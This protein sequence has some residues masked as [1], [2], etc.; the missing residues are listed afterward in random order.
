MTIILACDPGEKNFGMS[1][2][3]ITAK[4]V[5][6]LETDM[7]AETIVNL[8]SNERKMT[9]RAR[10]Q[11]ADFQTSLRRFKTRMG[12]LMHKYKPDH[13]V[14]ERF[15]TRGVKSRSAETV[16]M[17]NGISCHLAD[18]HGIGYR[19]LMAATWK[20]FVNKIFPLDQLYVLGHSVGLAN[21]TV[22]TLCIALYEYTNFLYPESQLTA[23][24]L[25]KIVREAGNK[26]E[27]LIR[28]RSKVKATWTDGKQ[29]PAVV[30]K[31]T[32]KFVKVRWYDGSG[33]AQLTHDKVQLWS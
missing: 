6:I 3:E 13:F 9:K 21:H 27:K 29:Y 10:D 5:R 20:N 11:E 32:P 26:F 16:S 17:M 24:A 4:R 18:N 7:I 31:V 23:A 8:T 28:V 22:D 33:T 14:A 25:Q 1:V 12:K 30:E 19:L 15:Q 2:V